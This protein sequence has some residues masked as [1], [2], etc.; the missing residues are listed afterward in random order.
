[1]IHNLNTQEI[2]DILLWATGLAVLTI[3][4]LLGLPRTHSLEVLAVLLTLIASVYLGFA[5][6]DGQLRNIIIE[7]TVALT[8]IIV[9]LLG[10]WVSPYFL[11]AGYVGH[12]V[13]DMVHS[14]T[15]VQTKVPAWYKPFCMVYDWMIAAF[16]VVWL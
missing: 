8:F 7:V 3:V 12:G 6:L 14:Q 1:M 15:L 16:I 2:R 5:I 11:L 9:A 10:L 4:I 13:W